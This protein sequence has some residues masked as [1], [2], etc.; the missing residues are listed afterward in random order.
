MFDH[1][2]ELHL[3]QRI[4]IR[5]RG[6]FSRAVEEQKSIELMAREEY[7]DRNNFRFAFFDNEFTH[8]GQLIDRYRRVR[9]RNGGSDRLSGFIR[10]ELSQTLFRQAG[11]TTTQTHRPA[12]V[13]LNGEYYGPAWLKSPR[14]PNHLARVFGGDSDRFETIEGGDRRHDSWWHGEPHA[15]RD[16]QQ[17]H[18]LAIAGFTGADGQQRFEDFSRRVDVDALIRYYAMQIYIN[19]LDWPNH[20]FELWRYFPTEEEK[21]DETLHPYL[22]DGR[23]RV[24]THDLEAGWAIWDNDDRTAFDDTLYHILTGTGERW[25]SSQSS[26]FLHAFVDREDTRAQLANTFVDLIEGA[27]APQNVIRTLNSLADQIR[28]EHSYAMQMDAIHPGEPWWPSIES[29]TEVHS[30]IRRFANDRP[31]V[32]L[33]SINRNLSFNANNR[34]L[35]TLTTEAGGGAVM[36]S[37]PVGEGQTVRGNYFTGTRIKITAQPNAGYAVDYWLVNGERHEGDYITVTRRSEVTVHFQPT[38]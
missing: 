13:F 29:T 6:G 12:A 21:N 32:I 38:T 34:Y 23:W 7:G 26:A 20:N 19:N 4:G 28:N 17:I 3:S 5:V 14:T 31:G 24:F 30:A 27:F 15:V 35:V 16:F 10:D 11:H 33:Q 1:K 22:R 18:R 8:D 25:N 37:R 9:L 2:G 36:N